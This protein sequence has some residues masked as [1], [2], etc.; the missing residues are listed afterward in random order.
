MQ[1]HKASKRVTHKKGSIEC[2]S[3]DN[4]FK[5]RDVIGDLVGGRVRP[6]ALSMPAEIK[7]KHTVRSCQRRG[8]MVPPMGV[9]RAAVE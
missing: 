8:N 7:G 3:G 6:G 2:K 1:C 5:V 4:A 9:G